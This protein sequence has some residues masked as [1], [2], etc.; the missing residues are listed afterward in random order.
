MA[1]R[2]PRSQVPKVTKQTAQKTTG[3][4]LLP[5]PKSKTKPKTHARTQDEGVVVAIGPAGGRHIQQWVTFPITPESIPVAV[6]ASWT[7]STIVGRDGGEFS[8]FGGPNLRSVSFSGRLEPPAYYTRSGNRPSGVGAVE[9]G[10]IGEDQERDL[11][12]RAQTGIDV[13]ARASFPT[14]TGEWRAVM[15]AGGHGGITGSLYLEPH[16][17]KELLTQVVLDGEIV[18][19]VVG[20]AYGLHMKASIREFTWRFEDPDPDVLMFDISL[21]EYRERDLLGVTGR[22]RPSQR[23]IVTK[24]GD[25]FRKLATRHWGDPGKA[26]YL[27]TI[28]ATVLDDIAVYAAGSKSASNLSVVRYA[29]E[30]ADYEPPRRPMTVPPPR[31]IHKKKTK[32]AKNDVRDFSLDLRFSDGIKLWLV[33]GPKKPKPKPKKKPR[34]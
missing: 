17:F 11:L 14:G 27:R 31:R 22:K 15:E 19:L 34:K 5:Q 7:D 12:K 16:A 10:G 21:R 13:G 4:A 29:K 32:G 28:N 20:D 9:F 18:D 2:R 1:V 23:Q 30:T 33:D 6:G 24:T 26:S 25:T 8:E 3:S